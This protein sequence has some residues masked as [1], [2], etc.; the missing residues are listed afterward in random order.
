M[1]RKQNS[2]HHIF[3]AIATILILTLSAAIPAHAQYDA[4]KSSPGTIGL[5]SSSSTSVSASTGDDTPQKGSIKLDLQVDQD[6]SI[7]T[8]T[9]MVKLQNLNA[10]EVEP[11]VQKSLS[12][13]GSVSTNSQANLLVITDREPKLTD[14]VEFVKK[15]DSLG[16]ENFVHLETEVIHLN[17]A[18]AST[19]LPILTRRLSSDGN[20]QAD[21]N[22]NVLVITDVRGK[23]DIVKDIISQLDRPAQQFIIEAKIIQIYDTDFSD[24]GLDLPALLDQG[25]I[26]YS[27][28]KLSEKDWGTGVPVT[29]NIRQKY[30]KNSVANYADQVINIMVGSGKAKLIANP[31]IVTLNNRQGTMRVENGVFYDSKQGPFPDIQLT[32]TPN[33]GA[34]G[35]ITIDF[36]AAAGITIVTNPSQLEPTP[37][38]NSY[39]RSIDSTILVHEGETFVVGGFNY[40]YTS[41]GNRRTPLL[42][43]IPV[44]GGIFRKKVTYNNTSQLLFFVTPVILKNQE[45]LPTSQESDAAEEK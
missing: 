23:I 32:A 3:F 21:D 13:Y 16:I 2:A 28:E 35:L 29:R 20:L 34:G 5:K 31:R 11:F 42:S 22:L 6:S 45:N 10:S 7:Y 33:I 38:S 40:D 19:L 8:K 15:M 27:T 14:L 24:V 25:V 39:L 1:A 12:S 44:L 18:K 26:S 9:V 37:P 30:S 4:Q 36:Q 17:T 41:S 43:D